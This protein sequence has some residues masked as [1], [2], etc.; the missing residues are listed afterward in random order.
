M[1]LIKRPRKVECFKGKPSSCHSKW[2]SDGK[3]EYYRSIVYSASQFGCNS[4]LML[5]NLER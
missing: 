3:P 4:T 1:D 5:I 2:T